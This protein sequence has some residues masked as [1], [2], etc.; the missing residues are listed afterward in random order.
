MIGKYCLP[1]SGVCVILSD[2]APTP[3][4]VPNAAQ[5][6]TCIFLRERFFL[7]HF[8]KMPLHLLFTSALWATT[9]VALHRYIDSD[10][11]FLDDIG[12]KCPAVVLNIQQ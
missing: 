7:I 12:K 8:L 1:G 5:T 10:F 9:S 11:C 6:C 2:P 4:I 3:V